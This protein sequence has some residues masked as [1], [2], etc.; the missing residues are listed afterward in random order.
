MLG[1]GQRWLGLSHAPLVGE[2]PTPF[3]GPRPDGPFLDGGR[4]GTPPLVRLK[5][6]C[7]PGDDGAPVVTV[8]LPDED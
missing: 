6:L 5:A 2:C 1:P 3:V 7:G 8:M 4:G